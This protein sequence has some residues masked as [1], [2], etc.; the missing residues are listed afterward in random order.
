VTLG[1]DRSGSTARNVQLHVV[2]EQPPSVVLVVQDRDEIVLVQQHRPGANLRVL[3]LPAGSIEPGE[4]PAEA[5][6]R[7]LAEECGLAADGWSEIGSFW[8]APEY[9]TEFVHVLAGSCSGVR[10]AEHDADEDITVVRLPPER[11]LAAL[12]DAGS[13]AALGLWMRQSP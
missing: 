3:E 5:A 11:A 12:E 10:H 9:S 6:D 4:T 1:R 13:V 2:I 8:L 7:E